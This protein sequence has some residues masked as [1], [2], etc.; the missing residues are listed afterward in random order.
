VDREFVKKYHRAVVKAREGNVEKLKARIGSVWADDFKKK[1]EAEG[2]VADFAADLEDFLGN[3]LRFCE[4]V[5]VNE[6][7]GELQLKVRGCHLCFGN[8]ELRREGSPALCP[9]VPTGLFSISRVGR[10]KATLKE[11]KKNGVVGDCE[12]VYKVSPK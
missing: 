1:T 5:E 12:I 8:E 10:N 3:D 2:G 6:E 11:V 9:I 7:N 4:K